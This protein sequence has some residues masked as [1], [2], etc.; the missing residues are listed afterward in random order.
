LRANTRRNFK[1]TLDVLAEV[2]NPRRLD[3]VTVRTVSVFAATLRSGPVRGRRGTMASTVKVRPQF[4]STALHWAAEQG[5]IAKCPKFPKVKLPERKP[6]PV[7][8]ESFERTLAKAPDA[9]MRAY[10]LCGWL[11]GLRLFEAYSLE[12]EP[13][14][15]AP[16]STWAATGSSCLPASSRARRTS[17]C[18]WTAGCVRPWR[19]CPARGAAC[20]T[21][22]PGGTDPGS[23]PARSATA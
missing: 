14:Q 19:P 1:D 11:A 6:Q 17:G 4:L 7:P 21:F 20:S 12:W 22:W 10:L 16:T 13:T 5:L 18:P 15:E 9:N 23:T 8:A 2:C 3:L